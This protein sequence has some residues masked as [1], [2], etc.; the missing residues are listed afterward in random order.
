[1]SR[2]E[3][4]SRLT[5]STNGNHARLRIATLDLECPVSLSRLPHPNNTLPIS[6]TNTA[7]LSPSRH[8]AKIIRVFLAGR[9]SRTAVD[10]GQ[11]TVLGLEVG[12][13]CYG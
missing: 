10:E 3:M 7:L 11:E 13:E 4:V 5:G 8:P 1:M 2:M 12:E 9:N 6:H